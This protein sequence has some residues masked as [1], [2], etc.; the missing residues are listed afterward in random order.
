[1]HATAIIPTQMST[2]HGIGFSNAVMCGVGIGWWWNCLYSRFLLRPVNTPN[3]GECQTLPMV[4][5]LGTFR[6]SASVV[7]YNAT[8]T[9]RS[10]TLPRLR[11]AL[12]VSQVRSCPFFFKKE[13]GGVLYVRFQGPKRQFSGHRRM[14]AGSLYLDVHDRRLT[15]A[16]VVDCDGHDGPVVRFRQCVRRRHVCRLHCSRLCCL[17]YRS[18]EVSPI[19]MFSI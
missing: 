13:C 3:I 18:S 6:C 7:V 8:H 16:G 1:M 9:S 5:R 12:R 17:Y 14:A 4:D 11:R 2:I 15:V 19:D 10:S